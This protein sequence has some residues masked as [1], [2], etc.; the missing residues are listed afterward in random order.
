LRQDVEWDCSI[1]VLNERS[2]HVGLGS[3][4]SLE[5]RRIGS[6]GK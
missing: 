2:G 4:G 3:V 5:W 1:P 6:G